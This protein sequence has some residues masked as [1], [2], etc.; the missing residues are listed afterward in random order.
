MH[1][2]KLRIANFRA[3]ENIDAEFDSLVSVIIGPNAIGKTTILEAIR[4]AK[5]RTNGRLLRVSYQSPGSEFG[6][7]RSEMADSLWRPFEKL[8]FL[9][10][11]GRRPGSI[12]AARPWLQW[13]SASFP[14]WRALGNAEPMQKSYCPRLVAHFPDG[15]S[16]SFNLEYRP[17][18]LPWGLLGMHYSNFGHGE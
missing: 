7:S 17:Q 14:P 3:I 13:N 10:D 12:Y 1:L 6:H 15:S 9:R 11:C 5:R 4:L 18:P 16:A 2:H 8:P